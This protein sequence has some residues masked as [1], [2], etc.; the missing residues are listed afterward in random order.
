MKFKQI[1]SKLYMVAQYIA[2]AQTQQPQQGGQQQPQN[3]SAAS[4]KALEGAK[5]QFLTAFKQ[6]FDADPNN[7]LT[8][9]N[10]FM[11]KDLPADYKTYYHQSQTGNNQQQGNQQQQGNNQQQQG[12]QQQQQN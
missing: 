5:Q 4:Q 3:N 9:L 2:E 11:T 1:E 10:N 7:A 8:W 6:Q 12:N